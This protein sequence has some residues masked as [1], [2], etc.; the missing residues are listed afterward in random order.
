MFEDPVLLRRTVTL[1]LIA[2]VAVYAT[3]AVGAAEPAVT[4]VAAGGLQ[5][6]RYVPR[7]SGASVEYS[8]RIALD[9]SLP[10]PADVLR[11]ASSVSP[12][13]P[14]TVDARGRR[15]VYA[16]RKEPGVA[17]RIVLSAARLR[18]AGYDVE[19]DIAFEFTTPS[20]V[21]IPSPLRPTPGEPYRY[22]A[23]ADEH[24]AA[25]AASYAALGVRFVRL[26]YAGHAIEPQ[27]GVFVWKD[28]DR[29]AGA[30]AEHGITELPIVTQYN[31]ADWQTGGRPYPA[32]FTSAEAYASFAGA[33]AAH[34]AQ[35]WPAIARIELMN[36]PNGRKWGQFYGPQGTDDSGAAAARYLRLAYAAVKAAAPSLTVV[37]PGLADGG[38]DVDARTYFTNL[39]LAGCRTGTC[40]DVLSVH[41]YDWENP[42]FAVDPAAQSQWLL[43]RQLQAIDRRSSH[44]T[45]HVM[46]TEWG[47]SDQR[48]VD[49]FAPAVVAR[50]LALGFNRMLADPTVDGIVYTHVV[51]TGLEHDFYGA[52]TLRADDGLERPG[53]RAFAAFSSGK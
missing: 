52:M 7:A 43:Y 24:V 3:S 42:D 48:S 5:G 15:A 40:W 46:I 20:P 9:L 32:I 25:R 41:T 4:L 35:R 45:P 22:G 19:R 18:D 27:P 10:L 11:S 2:I 50:Y 6:S 31:G 53:A 12:E 16:V 49:G 14:W 17:Y 33:V 47:Y 1:A 29:D 28:V 36:E 23:L 26:D 30:L 21:E 44:V 38:S 34:L 8:E 37:G 13:T 39:E 51:G